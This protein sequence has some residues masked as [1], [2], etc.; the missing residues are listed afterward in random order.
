MTSGQSRRLLRW[1]HAR[2]STEFT[3]DLV[4]DPHTETA[5]ALLNPLW[6]GR[7]ERDRI[8]NGPTREVDLFELSDCGVGAVHTLLPFGLFSWWCEHPARLGWW[9]TRS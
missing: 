3:L 5:F 6:H 1:C 7:A 4:D 8:R 9:K 2:D